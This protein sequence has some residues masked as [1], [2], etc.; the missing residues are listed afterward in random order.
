MSDPLVRFPERTVTFVIRD[1]SP[2]FHMQEPPTKRTVRIQLTNDQL[3][4]LS[5]YRTGK[6]DGKTTY[7][8]VSQCFLETQY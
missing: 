6:I 4:Q 5:L 7:E 1:D 2:F 8:T 3:S